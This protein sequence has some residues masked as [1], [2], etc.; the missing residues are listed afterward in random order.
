MVQINCNVKVDGPIPFTHSCTS[1]NTDVSARPQQGLGTFP[2]TSKNN[3]RYLISQLAVRMM[4][5][6]Y[7]WCA[8]FIV[9]GSGLS[10][11]THSL[12]SNFIGEKTGAGD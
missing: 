6:A 12:T 1:V 5:S 10:S 2:K 4:A 7:S 3:P 8:D 9:A 11:K